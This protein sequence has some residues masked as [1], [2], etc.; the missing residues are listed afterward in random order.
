V[1]PWQAFVSGGII[2]LWRFIH[3][4]EETEPQSHVF[5]RKRFLVGFVIGFIPW[6]MSTLMANCAAFAQFHVTRRLAS[7]QQIALLLLIVINAGILAL[8]SYD[9]V[10]K[11][12]APLQV[13]LVRGV[14]PS[15]EQLGPTPGRL[16]GQVFGYISQHGATPV[17]PGMTLYYDTEYCERDIHVGACLSVL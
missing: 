10:L 6:L 15:M 3:W 11:K 4:E 2:S 13:V 1:P 5:S 7:L 17:G 8:A 9:G 12:V 14:A 16:F